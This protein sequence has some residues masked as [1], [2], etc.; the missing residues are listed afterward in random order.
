MLLKKKIGENYKYN[1]Y[2]WLTYTN[3]NAY[4]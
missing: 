4:W 1:I 3:I 2:K